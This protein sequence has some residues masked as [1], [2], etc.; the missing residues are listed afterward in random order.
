[1]GD[2]KKPA[3]EK[4]ELITLSINDTLAASA[5]DDDFEFGGIS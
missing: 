3:W 2:D 4:P 5:P 1:M